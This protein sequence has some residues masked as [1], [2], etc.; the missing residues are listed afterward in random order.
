MINFRKL[1]KTITGSISGKPF[2]ITKTEEAVAWLTQAQKDGK[3]DA[4][5]W[6]YI[7]KVRLG[8]V[9]GSNKYLIHNPVTKE[10]FLTLDGVRSKH[11]IPESLVT[12]I[13]DSFDKDI[14]FMPVLKA[15]ARLLTNPRYNKEMGMWFGKYVEATYT[16][17]IEA[18]KISA[19][20]EIEFDIAKNMCTYQDISIA[21]EGILVS[22]K[23]AEVVDWEYLME[24]NEEDDTYTKVMKKKYKVIPAQID[25]TTGEV[26]TK[27]SYEKPA[28]LEEYLFTPA[29][30]KDGDK[31]YSGQ[32]LGYV[33]EVGKMQHLPKTAKRNLQNTFGGGGLYTGGLRYI[34]SYNS[35]SREVLV[36]FVNP[37]DIISF[38]DE[39]G[40]FRTD[41]IFPNNVWDMDV[42]LK[43]TYHSSDYDKLSSARLEEI[44]AEA[45]KDGV[46]IAEE[47]AN[48]LGGVGIND[49]EK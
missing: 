32:K 7:A 6:D 2:N 33:Y 26:I 28:S 49:T 23:V 13:E 9:A 17:T 8:E 48:Y 47:Q 10:Y 39:G 14:D 27:E 20:Q 34:E 21:Q 45:V 41:A 25:T 1:D 36:C 22:Y 11:A 44:V 30:C 4:D 38:Q 18:E 12:F 46:N 42:P 16:D 19:E 29:I 15:W 35:S 5:V 40:A 31:F 24:H 37:A 43:G 3:P